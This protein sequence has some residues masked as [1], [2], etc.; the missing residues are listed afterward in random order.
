V[1]LSLS[2]AEYL[3][4]S[5]AGKMALYLCSIMDNLHIAQDLATI[6]YEDNRGALLMT[7]ATQPTKQTRHMEFVI[8]P[9]MI[10]L[11]VISSL[12][13]IAPPVSLPRISQQNKLAVS[14]SLAISPIFPED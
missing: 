8:M 9:S 6:I 5:D 3:A 7:R 12:L 10:G 11:S 14:Y 2:E 13:R 4:A 1:S